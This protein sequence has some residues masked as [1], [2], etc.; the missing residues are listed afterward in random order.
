[1][2]TDIK[3]LSSK[4]VQNLSYQ[5][6][7]NVPAYVGATEYIKQCYDEGKVTASEYDLAA[8]QVGMAEWGIPQPFV[9]GTLNTYYYSKNAPQVLKALVDQSKYPTTGDVLIEVT[10]LQAQDLGRTVKISI[11]GLADTTKYIEFSGYDFAKLM[12]A[13]S[14]TEKLGIA[15]YNY[16]FMANA[17]WGTDA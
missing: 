4:E 13:N 2:L 12:T 16:G 8:K 17:C 10:G 7:L 9:T 1:M 14:S 3:Y 15:L 11:D 6:C 5:E